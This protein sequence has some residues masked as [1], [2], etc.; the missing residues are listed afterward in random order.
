MAATLA[1]ATIEQPANEV[2][3]VG[4]LSQTEGASSQLEPLSQP[5]LVVFE[6]GGE[7][8][9]GVPPGLEPQQSQD[10]GFSQGMHALE[11]SAPSAVDL[12]TAALSQFV[13][14]EIIQH[15]EI[16]Q[17]ANRAGHDTSSV[18]V[19]Y[20]GTW[21]QLRVLLLKLAYDVSTE[22]NWKV[23]GFS[24]YEGP[25]P[26]EPKDPLQGSRWYLVV[27]SSRPHPLAS[28]LSGGSSLSQE[29]IGGCLQDMLR[30]S[31]LHLG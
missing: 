5:P 7:L 21:A 12:S 1:A 6:S 30:R 13:E 24:M 8:G 22:D 14:A 2:L 28:G 19:C 29:A 10:T 9:W 4:G 15:F 18:A 3:W 16:V 20:P 11:V 23:L 26:T 17:A 31:G 25:D 27:R